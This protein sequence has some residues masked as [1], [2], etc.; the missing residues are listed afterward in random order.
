[1]THNTTFTQMKRN[2]KF[3]DEGFWTPQTYMMQEL[4]GWIQRAPCNVSRAL[5]IDNSPTLD[6]LLMAKWPAINIQRA[7]YPEHDVQNLFYFAEN[8]FDLV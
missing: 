7:V 6:P 1:M 5:S 2:N 8:F 4:D 3:T